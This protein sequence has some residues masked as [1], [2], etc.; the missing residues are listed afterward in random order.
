MKT[1]SCAKAHSKL[2]R[3]LDEMG[4]VYFPRSGSELGVVRNSAYLSSDGDV[5]VFVDM[6]QG[7]LLGKSYF[8]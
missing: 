8:L 6:P 2:W 7:K 4:V 5:D 3:A 1:T